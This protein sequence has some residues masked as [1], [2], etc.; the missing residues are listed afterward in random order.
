MVTDASFLEESQPLWYVTE[1]HISMTEMEMKVRYPWYN[2]F[3]SSIQS[4][5]T[6]KEYLKS[7]K[8]VVTMLKRTIC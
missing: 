3:T 7:R 2:D 4:L 6:Y 5:V 1:L 8:M